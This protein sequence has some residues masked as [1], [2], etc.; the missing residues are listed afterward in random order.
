MHQ[1]RSDRSHYCSD[2]PCCQPHTLTTHSI[3]FTR[4]L[5]LKPAIRLGAQEYRGEIIKAQVG[6]AKGAEAVEFQ[7]I[8]GA[9]CDRLSDPHF[10]TAL[11]TVVGDIEPI[12]YG[13]NINQ[14]DSTR[15]DQVLLT[16][17]GIYLWFSD[18]PEPEVAAGMTA[19]IEKHWKDS[20]QP[21]F[22]LALILNP[23]EGLLAF[24]P[25]A[26]LSHF[27]C[28]GLLMS[29]RRCADILLSETDNVILDVPAFE[30]TS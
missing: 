15:A 10:W 21:L 18:H 6:A 13:T 9:H 22:L 3:A 2:I 16:L 5:A 24:G 23:F 19:D 14:A 28:N 8:S 1:Q 27:K 29:V 26:D 7:Q 11:E 4:L 20:D 12:T 17:A 25:R 30:S